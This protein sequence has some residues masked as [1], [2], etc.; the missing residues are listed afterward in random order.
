[1]TAGELQ[2]MLSERGLVALSWEWP[3]PTAQA[4]T[5][6]WYVQAMI[7]FGAW[8]AGLLFI[9]FLSIVTMSSGRDRWETPLVLGVLLCVTTGALFATIATKS[10][11]ANQIA[12]AL[13]FGGQTGIAVGLGM[14]D[15]GAKAVLWGMLLVEIALVF[16]VNNRYHRF[17]STIAAVVAWALAV[18]E[19][20][21]KD[22]PGGWAFSMKFRRPR[23][24]PTYPCP[25][26]FGSWFGRH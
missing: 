16:A 11:F 18:D 21:L 2:G 23:R 20:L 7:G 14:S 17:L 13:S 1:M 3:Q 19:L 10:L 6:P 25:W 24:A 22:S 15:G 5:T 12:L 9:V 8:L 26:S 4:P